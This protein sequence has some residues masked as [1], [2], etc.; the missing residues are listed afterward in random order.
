[1]RDLLDLARMNRTD[2]S[3]HPSEIDLAEVAEDAV[4][5]YQPQA[6]S[7]R[8]RAPRGVGR[9]RARDRRRRPRA[10]DRLE[11]RRERAAADAARR[12]G[13]RRHRTRRAARRGHRP[14]P[15]GRRPPRAFE[16][17]YLHERYGR[18]R[19][20]GTGL[21]LAIVKELTVAM[22][23]TVSVESVPGELTAFTVR[24][25]KPRARSLSRVI[26]IDDVER[27]RAND[28][29]PRAPHASAA[30][31]A[32]G[33]ARRRGVPQGGALPAHRLVQGSR[34]A[35]PDRGADA[36]R[37]GRAASSRSRPATTRRRSRGRRARRAST[38]SS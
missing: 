36:T 31:D 13:A 24:L 28:R 17:F 32:L 21:G 25:A 20:V 6:D 16:R 2:F 3:V 14:G 30:R 1:M 26:S 22:G 37:S 10:P 11:P 4:R 18:E 8:R 12:R 33:A 19:P 23:G 29:R 35:Q 15:R 5:R 9:L 34:R 27:G 7:V 38:R